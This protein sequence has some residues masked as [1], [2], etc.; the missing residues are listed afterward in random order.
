[1]HDLA[2]PDGEAGRFGALAEGFNML[3]PIKATVN[4]QPACPRPNACPIC[5][6]GMFCAASH[7]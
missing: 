7:A 1:M 2:L 4:G 3:D 5:V 6:S